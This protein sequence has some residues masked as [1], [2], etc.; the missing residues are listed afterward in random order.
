MSAPTT[1]ELIRRGAAQHGSRTAYHFGG[2]DVGVAETDRLSNRLAN[3]LRTLGHGHHA[4]VAILLDNGLHS[5]PLDFACVKAG[6]NRV[7]LNGRLSEDEHARMI[8]GTACALLVHGPE[9][10][11]RTK[12]LAAR[13]PDLRLLGLDELLAMDASDGDP[14]MPVA[15]DD[16]IL[17]LFTSGTTG[18]LKAAQHTQASYAAIGRNLMLNLI[19]IRPGDV[20]MHAASLIHASGVFVIPYWLRGGTSVILPGFD[21][22]SYLA[23]MK[24]HRA[25]AVNMVPTML[26]MLLQQEA[27]DDD[28]PDL[29]QLIYGASP[30]PRPLI[31]QAMARWGRERFWQY[32]GQTEC[33]LCIAVLRPEDHVGE[34]LGACGQP[35]LDVEIRLVDADG[36]D[37]PAGEAGEIA[38]RAPSM[39]AG[40]HDAPELNADTFTADG[41]L[42]TRDIGQFDEDGFLYL[43]DRTSDMI[44]TGGYNVYPREVEDA[45]MAHE[46]VSE[47]AVI[48]LPDDK[49]VEAVT[50][51]V[52]LR[53]EL[54]DEALIAFVGERL[55]GYKKPRRVIRI[56]AIPKTAVG[57]LDRRALR[58]RFEP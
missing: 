12:A 44:V 18:R 13:C 26:Q 49:W 43:R 31:E 50:A 25:T 32:Y 53:N 8:A 42:R 22:A 16:V 55:A 10:A 23:D 40:Y 33:P 54:A 41:W 52:V 2:E 14:D 7:P 4:R 1:R 45:L 36:Q 5:I 24:R 29:R 17:T 51:V 6:I 20:M 57:K 35:A 21:P 38:V 34:R 58:E 11:G 19:D 47:C 9:H 27:F 15:P 39:M 30:M 56:D 3:A 48:G 46:A 37:V 28:Y